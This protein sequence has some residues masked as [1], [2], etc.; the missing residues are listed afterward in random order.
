MVMM[1]VTVMVYNI[2]RRIT[3][4]S[5]LSSELQD[6]D[7]Y[8]FEYKLSSEIFL[9]TDK[10]IQIVVAYKFIWSTLTYVGCSSSF[11]FHDKFFHIC[12]TGIFAEN[13]VK[14]SVP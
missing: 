10:G 2:L 8:N 7:E 5:R 3:I 14:E 9:S 11:L 4:D 1:M 6:Y 13:C 12:Y